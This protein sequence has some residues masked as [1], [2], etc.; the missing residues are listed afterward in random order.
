MKRDQRSEIGEQ[1]LAV[2]RYGGTAVRFF[3]RFVLSC[4]ASFV[5]TVALGI[6][7]VFAAQDFGMFDVGK[8][9]NLSKADPIAIASNLINE[10]LQFVGILLLVLILWGGFLYMLSGGS[11]ERTKKAVGVIRN[12]IIGVIIILC[13]WGIARFALTSLVHAT[14][15]GG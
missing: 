4:I 2:R 7:T 5:S 1:K 15:A 10:A 8:G 13:A 3:C 9:L 11:E 14:G 6:S 12:A